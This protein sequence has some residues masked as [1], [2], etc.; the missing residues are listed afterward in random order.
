VALCIHILL[1]YKVVNQNIAVETYF[2]HVLHITLTGYGNRG[3][4]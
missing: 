4:Y 2:I 1:L 3:Y